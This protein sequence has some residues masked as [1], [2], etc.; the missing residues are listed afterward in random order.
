M[1]QDS[2]EQEEKD[3][4]VHIARICERLE[5]EATLPDDE[6]AK[7][8]LTRLIS[9][10]PRACDGAALSGMPWVMLGQLERIIYNCRVLFGDDC[11]EAAARQ[12]RAFFQDD[13]E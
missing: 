10:L 8:R 3:L 11:F 1:Y 9:Q 5:W 2:Y 6:K 4:N 12:R 13:E 7:R